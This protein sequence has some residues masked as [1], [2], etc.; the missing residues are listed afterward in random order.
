MGSLSVTDQAESLESLMSRY[1]QADEAAAAALV[2][3]VTPLLRRYFLTQASNR[4]HADDLL[5]D[6]WMRLH[7][8]RH[9]YRPGEPV[10]PWVLAIARYAN[11]DHYRKSSRRDAHE[12]QVD[13]LPDPPGPAAPPSDVPDIDT[14]LSALPERQREVI[15]MLKI[16]GMSVDEVARA[17]SSSPGSVRQK[18]HR[19]YQKLREILSVPRRTP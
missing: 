6:T 15:V 13:V 5:Q 8:A 12:R 9:T 7:R 16:S 2:R 17:T 10:L 3:R 18:A 19:A 1:Q 4:I 11:L 14:M